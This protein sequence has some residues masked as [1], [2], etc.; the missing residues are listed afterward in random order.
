MNSANDF[1]SPDHLPHVD[2]HSSLDDLG[3]VE[4]HHPT[5][6]IGGDGHLDTQTAHHGDEIVIASDLDHDGD[7]D[8]LK[9]IDRDGEYGA[10]EYRNDGAGTHWVRTENGKLGG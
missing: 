4:L 6:S 5:S 2:A 9:V 7:A 8:H 10:W 1:L 3:P